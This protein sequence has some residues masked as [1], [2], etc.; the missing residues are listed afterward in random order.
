MNKSKILV[1]FVLLTT[2]LAGI[3][4]FS[5]DARAQTSR[6]MNLQTLEKIAVSGDVEAQLR[7]AEFYSKGGFHRAEYK[8]KAA[9]WREKA[10]E[11]QSTEEYRTA[12]LKINE[13]K[14]QELGFK[15]EEYYK[16]TEHDR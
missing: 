11:K 9:Y 6:L 3:L 15:E 10:G 5:S 2:L 1:A 8:S 4:Y 12:L 14:K 7:L 13:E 16:K